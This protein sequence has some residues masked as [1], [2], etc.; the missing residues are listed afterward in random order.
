MNHFVCLSV[1][2]FLK[3]T[4]NLVARVSRDWQNIHLLIITLNFFLNLNFFFH[5]LNRSYGRFVLVLKRI[6]SV[7]WVKFPFSIHTYKYI[8]T[9]ICTLYIIVHCTITQ[10]YLFILVFLEDKLVN[11]NRLKII[12]FVRYF[13][14]KIG[15]GSIEH[16]RLLLVGT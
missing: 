3:L 11:I 15:W 1:T 13:Q 9:N 7:L 14:A 16:K 5:Y 4:R 6:A 2:L 10:I 12:K 8:Q